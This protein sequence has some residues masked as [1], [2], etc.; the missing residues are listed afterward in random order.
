MD[1]RVDHRGNNYGLDRPGPFF[2]DLR[3]QRVTLE[4][5]EREFIDLLNSHIGRAERIVPYLKRKLAQRPL[6]EQACRQR[7]IARFYEASAQHRL[8]IRWTRK[9]L[10]SFLLLGRP[11]GIRQC[12]RMLFSS[13]THLGQ[14]NNARIYAEKALE[15]TQLPYSERLKIL[16][17]LGGLEYRNHNYAPALH[18]FKI[19]LRL[20]PNKGHH[21][22]RAIVL[23]NVANLYVSLNK[24]VEADQNYQ[25]ASTLFRQLGLSLYEAHARQ[26]HGML[27]TILGQYF[28]AERDLK[29]AQ[30]VYLDG[31]DRLGGALC[32]IE[33]FRLDLRLN[34][35]ENVLN[36]T[37][38][39]VT[40]FKKLGRAFEM[41]L[42]Y[43]YAA[44]AA[45]ALNEPALC[46]EYLEQA[47]TLFRREQNRHFQALCIMLQGNLLWRAGRDAEA[48]VLIYRAK[49]A[50]V[51]ENQ[52]ELELQCLIYGS[53]IQSGN[54][55][56]QAHE[57]IR[58]LIKNPLNPQV[59]IQ[60][61]ITISNYW[62]GRGQ[63][64]RSIRCLLEAVNSIEESRASIASEQLRC[65]FF[66]DKTEAYELLI[67]RLF[68]WKDAGAAKLIFKV[69]ELSRGRQM[70]EVLSQS[71]DLPPVLNRNEP[72]IMELHRL[73][74]RL[75][76]LNRKWEEL[77]TDDESATTEKTTLEK[78]LQE[79]K[80][81]RARLKEQMSHEGR[82]GMFFPIEL[83]A[84]KLRP[85]LEPHQL[86]VIYFLN[87]NSL[88]RL[89][90]KADG[91]KTYQTQLYDRFESDLN[92]MLNWL[93]SR[94]PNKTARILEYA[95]R[96]S[97]VLLPVRLRH[98]KHI[99]FVPHKGLQRFP[100]AMLRR[101]KGYLIESH[102]LSQC[103]NLPTFYFSFKK[104]KSE[105]S[106]PVF[107][108]SDHPEDPQALERDILHRQFKAGKV[109][110]NLT[111]THLARHIMLSDFI[112][113]AGH[114]YF[115]Q[116]EPVKSC[117]QLNGNR[118]TLGQIAKLRLMRQPF[119]NL[120][121]CQSG[122]MVLGA[123]NEPYGFV[124]SLFA[125]GSASILASLWDIDDQATG[126][127]M[128]HFY[129]HLEEGLAQAYRA[130]C[131]A[132]NK[133]G[134]PPYFWAG[135]CLLGKC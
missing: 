65:S 106:K 43:Y 81:A 75:K 130:T 50:F 22:T 133:A 101:E 56:R 39:L 28:R 110:Q 99:I 84:E 116:R 89:E 134:E 82:L 2:Q 62:Y 76:H 127:W 54:I 97:K 31:G 108:F 67:E 34:R 100:W 47:A 44:Q 37:D 80:Q 113:F 104:K 122:W 78:S 51:A 4:Q 42:I 109:F 83:K 90:L 69:I 94:L 95:D 58:D 128:T 45:I 52:P 23:Y 131:L 18:Y 66:Q 105:F 25:K 7:L 24:F 59:R 86:L 88:Y 12:L 135:F 118:V 16:V 21:Q 63:L 49:D 48:L 73:E 132:M 98:V 126:R 120:A 107:L 3:R 38:T 68:H 119:I 36:R 103:P 9:A 30:K 33:L 112:H 91:L 60:A 27:F 13:Y 29:K 41:G 74:L 35:Y 64:K 10:H 26:A 93:S 15:D 53:R 20:L 40:T 70:S 57:R 87:K 124:I 125:A 77:T 71:Q 32:D 8:A 79:T 5:L 19:A 85:L 11:G 17:N 114:C 46:G 123:G 96:L 121:A 14:Y 72:S 115:N 102:A 117:L 1:H 92:L 61:L 55:N 129:G 6:E 111:A